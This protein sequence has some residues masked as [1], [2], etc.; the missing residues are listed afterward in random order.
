MRM[1]ISTTSGR[2]V[3]RQAHRLVAVHG[4]A[5]DGDV[6]LGV[7][8]GV[9]AG[10][11]PAPGRRRCRTVITTATADCGGQVGRR[12]GTRRPGRRRRR[13]CRPALRPAR[14]IPV[15]PLPGV[16]G[17]ADA[18]VD[19]P[20]RSRRR[21]RGRS[22][23]RRARRG[24]GGTRWS[25]PPGRSGRR[26]ARPPPAAARRRRRC[27]G[28][29]RGRWPHR[30]RPAGPARPGP[31]PAP[32]ARPRRGAGSSSAPR[33]SCSASRLACLIVGRAP[34]RARSGC[35]SIRCSATPAC[36]LISEMWW[37]EHVVQLLGQLQPL[38]A[39]AAL[40]L[41]LRSPAR[42]ATCTSRRDR[43]SSATASTTISHPATS[44]SG[45]STDPSWCGSTDAGGDEGDVAGGGQAP[46]AAPRP[47]Q[48]GVH[49]RDDHADEDRAVGVAEP[50]VDRRSRPA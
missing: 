43:T 48:H 25:A 34:A 47:A 33:S 45:T 50:D 26:P 18:V 14:R 28:G 42:R 5:D 23:R 29:R 7:E 6:V 39:G 24:R 44:T 35:S 38:L 11:A 32:A 40:A 9:E 1:S 19:A 2:S 21:R 3:G 15:I 10:R 16:G 4:L 17:A 36:T 31:G 8:Q 37:A 22:D 12:R 30:A 41:L 13:R 46:R 49:E 27:R 20:R